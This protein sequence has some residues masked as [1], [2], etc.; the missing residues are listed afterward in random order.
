MND[1]VP[2]VLR[3]PRTATNSLLRNAAV[4]EG[5]VDIAHRE[6]RFTDG[7]RNVLSKSEANLL[8]YFDCNPGRVISRAEI[9]EHV[10]RV[11]P[12]CT[13]TRT[14][15]MHVSKLRKKLRDNARAPEILRT[16]NRG[17]YVLVQP[18]VRLPGLC[19]L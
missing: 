1:C 13:I 16:V 3:R 15:D 2:T 10:W 9:L 6:I 8:D 4:P 12:A 14:V 5:V 7:E 17:G 18:L 11:N 19:V